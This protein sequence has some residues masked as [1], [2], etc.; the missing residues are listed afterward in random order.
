MPAHTGDISVNPNIGS[1]EGPSGSPSVNNGPSGQAG[2]APVYQPQLPAA[3]ETSYGAVGAGLGMADLA[4]ARAAAAARVK[5]ENEEK[6]RKND[7][8]IAAEAQK[9]QAE[10]KASDTPESNKVSSQ[11]VSRQAS[12]EARQNDA[13]P[14]KVNSRQEQQRKEQVQ[15]QPQETQK[16]PELKPSVTKKDAGADHGLIYDSGKNKESKSKKIKNVDY[17]AA[18]QQGAGSTQFRNTVKPKPEGRTPVDSFADNLNRPPKKHGPTGFYVTPEGVAYPDE[19]PINAIVKTNLGPTNLV[20]SNRKGSETE[21]DPERPWT[22]EG[23]TR[24]WMA[25]QW[26]VASQNLLP[27]AIGGFTYSASRE[28]N[29][30]RTEEQVIDDAIKAQAARIDY[31]QMYPNAADIGLDYVSFNQYASDYIHGVGENG[32]D[33]RARGRYNFDTLRRSVARA[34]ESLARILRYYNEAYIPLK[35]EHVDERG[36][37]RFEPRTETAIANFMN[38]MGLAP[39]ERHIVFKMVTKAIGL[40]PDRDG[41]FFSKSEREK[42]DDEV[43][44]EALNN[45]MVSCSE[46]G[47]PY[48]FVNRGMVLGGTR[49]Y[50]VGV[51]DP[52]ELRILCSTG[53]IFDG[54]DPLDILNR[55]C[56]TWINE[57]YPNIRRNVYRQENG[58]AQMTMIEDFVRA[59]CSLHGISPRLFRVSEDIDRG[60]EAMK[61]E[62]IP[63]Y[64]FNETPE[65]IA[66]GERRARILDLAR[67]RYDRSVNRL[68]RMRN[69]V[70]EVYDEDV[71]DD[72][73]VVLHRRGDRVGR[74]DERNLAN[75]R[76]VRN[77]R[78]NAFSSVCMSVANM[79]KFAGVVGYVPIM[80]SG[81][82]EHAQGNVNAKISNAI[83]FGRFN[84]FNRSRNDEF[85]PNDAMYAHVTSEAGVEGIAAW[86]SLMHVGGQDALIMFYQEYKVLN[87]ENAQKFINDFVK[88]QGS[89]ALVP[90]K[91]KEL[92]SRAEEAVHWLMPGDIGFSK[93]DARRWLEGFMLNNMYNA[94][95]PLDVELSFNSQ[96]VLEM[97]DT[98]GIE[99]FLAAA[100]EM[101]AGRDAMIMARNQTFDR[102]SPLTYIV[103][104]ML[105]ANGVTNMFVTLGIDTYFTYGLNLIQMMV[106]FSNTASYLA[107]KGI[108][109]L[110]TGGRNNTDQLDLNILNYQLGG[111]DDFGIGLRKNVV[112]DCVK[113]GNICLI[114]GFMYFVVA[115][116]GFDE[117]E[118]P[119]NKYVWSE[120]RIGRNINLGG[121]DENGNPTGIP[122]Y[123][124]WWLNDLTMFALPMAYALNARQLDQKLGD[125]DPEL[126]NKLFFSGCHDMLSGCSLLDMMKIINNAQDD[127]TQYEQMMQDPDMECP[128]D[129]LSF[130]L[131]QMELF[132]ANGANKFVPNALKS[133]R[134]DTLIVGDKA[135]DHTAYKVYDRESEDPGKTEYV[136][137]WFEVQRRV[138]SKFNPIYALYNNLTKNGYLFDDGSTGKTGY[139]FDEMP[140][141]TAKD[142][143]RMYWA[144]K[145]EYDPDNI[146]GG[147]ENRIPYTES[148]MDQVIEDID[149]FNSVDE[150]LSQ[151]F[152]IP[153]ALRFKMRDYC[154][155]HINF[156]E[157][158]F[159]QKLSEGWLPTAEYNAA[160]S[161]MKERQN[162]WY[163]IIND[164]VFNKDIPWTDEGYAKLITSNQDVYYYKDSGKPCT[165]FDY[166][167]L[168][169]ETVEQRYIPRGDHPTSF[170][171]FTTPDPRD[172]GYNYETISNWY[173]EGESGSDLQGIFDKMEKEGAVVPYG[174]DQGVY[175][176][177]SIFGGDPNFKTNDLI[178]SNEYRAMNEPT[179]GYRAYVPWEDSFLFDLPNFNGYVNEDGKLVRDDGTKVGTTLAMFDGLKSKGR[180]DVDGDSSMG[181]M[182][183]YKDKDEWKKN[184]YPSYYR[185]S[186]GWSKGGRRSYGGGSSS[187]NPKIYSTRAS[188]SHV[189]STHVSNTRTNPDTRSVNTDRAATM[190]SKQLQD[191]KVSTYLRPGFST[192]GSREAY[193]R[194]DI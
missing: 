145:Y 51:P 112:Y 162:Y 77:P 30:K 105:R 92:M 137:D 143:L 159:N 18:T 40:T 111:N 99:R 38:Y 70:Y 12:G 119:L 123:A 89:S 141:S 64:R 37:I 153:S 53:H 98:M 83:L 179:M 84:P 85:V 36:Y 96:Q 47:H 134:T 58:E 41:L 101:N 29:D 187:Y 75:T 154:Y 138:E 118:D 20:L 181:D 74:N 25:S 144:H 189:D 17:Y 23:P 192:K 46:Y 52:E 172:R 177:T 156:E 178:E 24:P 114:A 184:S 16:G 116:L 34:R 31:D 76:Y 50:P 133:L 61:D 26:G 13:Q 173:K 60:Y 6:R 163:G 71:V 110:A 63:G 81:I 7:Q 185:K 65:D 44:I 120:Y 169:P 86:K 32:E 95:D 43:F 94:N 80:A 180:E 22:S 151:G 136:D 160:K 79:A 69:R 161:E 100:T 121:N 113:L 194:Q 165:K 166:W 125:N 186:G 1:Y 108:N 152:M 142:P 21:G 155:Q 15:E 170:A 158:L 191:T 104:S 115:A 57:T 5:A 90:R 175:V 150:A 122:V 33:L 11:S 78:A 126:A 42:I 130:G 157:N 39:E 139:L 88:R 66:V 132:C 124:A 103:D 188:S 82:V 9:K 59:L 68:D 146:P 97:M 10:R 107:V 135:L 117:P 48:G 149:S 55:C 35:S 28:Q 182:G 19:L 127:F 131:L 168:G 183:I 49:C 93:A 91:A 2:D 56:E 72:N 190:Y 27:G 167:Q 102:I 62:C 73:G 176:N 8:R 164:W 129:W 147:E 109:M 67:R 193:K 106:P 3:G 140:I 174:R 54:Q 87:K 45:M 148:L 171:P 14:T 128:P 4:A